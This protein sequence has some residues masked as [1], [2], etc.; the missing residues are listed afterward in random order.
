MAKNPVRSERWKYKLPL[1]E[2]KELIER[3]DLLELIHGSLE[4][5]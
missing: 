4:K 2:K 3:E 1:L 5:G